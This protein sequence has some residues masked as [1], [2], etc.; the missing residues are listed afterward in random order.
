MKPTLPYIIFET[1]TLCNL[2]C[3]YCYNIWKRPG[4]SIIH[5]AT[6]KS[7]IRTLKKLFA[8]AS[9]NSITFTGGEPLLTERFSELVLF[10]KLKKASVNVITNG[11]TGN[12]E[13]YK[14]LASQLL[15]FLYSTSNEASYG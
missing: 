7:A 5:S 6:Y 2:D 15:N 3:L 11:C 8:S 9:V 12:Y 14:E 4:E 1:N 10:C 13:Q